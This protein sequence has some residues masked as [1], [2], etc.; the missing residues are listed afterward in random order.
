MEEAK[1]DLIGQQFALSVDIGDGRGIQINGIF[2][3]EDDEVVINAQLDK[4]WNI[5]ERMRARV[6]VQQLEDEIRADRQKQND[7][8]AA[9]Q[10]S[11][12]E[13][14]KFVKV[15]KIVPSRLKV[16]AETHIKSMAAGDAMIRAKEATIEVLRKKLDGMG[17][18]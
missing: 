13:A 10:A 16:D 9:Y 6:R 7:A 17:T 14:E 1:K 5:T 15:G 12:D 8:E 18:L 4:L 3:R 11:F 2:L